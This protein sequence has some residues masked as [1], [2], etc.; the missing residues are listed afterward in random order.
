VAST[1]KLGAPATYCQAFLAMDWLVE[2]Y[3]PAKVTEFLGRFALDS[4]PPD[5]WAKVFPISYRRFADEFRVRLEN[6]AG[7]TP[8]AGA[9]SLGASQPS[10][11]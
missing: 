9:G 4:P 6:L 11:G 1:N 5:H 2:R 10:C 8:A 3:G 7:S